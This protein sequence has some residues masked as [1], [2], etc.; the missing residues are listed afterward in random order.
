VAQL[1]TPRV[2]RV[3]PLA[4]TAAALAVIE[5]GHVRGKLAIAI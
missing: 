1:A 5:S 4:D 2:E 3:Y